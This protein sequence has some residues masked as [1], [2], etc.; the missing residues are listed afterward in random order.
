M[1]GS[2]CSIENGFE[3]DRKSHHPTRHMITPYNSSDVALTATAAAAAQND[4]AWCILFS[5]RH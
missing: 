1:G 5:A 3:A 2:G 4:S